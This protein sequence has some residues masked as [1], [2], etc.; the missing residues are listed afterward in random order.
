M[1]KYDEILN[2]LVYQIDD[3]VYNFYSESNE[4]IAA[5]NGQ[6]RLLTFRDKTLNTINDMNVRSLEIIAGFKDSDL[7]QERA[8]HLLEKNKDIVNSALEVLRAAPERNEFFDDLGNLATGIFESAK[9]TFQKVEESETFDRF[10][11]GALS[12]LKKMQKGLD[13]LAK[14]PGVVKSTEI[15]KEKTKEAVDAGTQIVKDT[16]KNV[17][18]WVSEQELRAKAEKVSKEVHAGAETVKVKVHDGAEK[19]SEIVEDTVETK[20]HEFEEDAF[21]FLDTLEEELDQVSRDAE[22]NLEPSNIVEAA[23]KQVRELDKKL[24]EVKEDEE[25]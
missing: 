23:E 18:D 1:S 20:A 11:E 21:S 24:D 22:S 6:E 19:V 12:G 4:I 16:S 7:I 10:K 5:K 3:V 8:E 9:T 2:E 25:V 14:H 13:D 17:T 15:V